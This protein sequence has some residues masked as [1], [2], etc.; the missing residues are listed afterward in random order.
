MATIVTGVGYTIEIDVSGLDDFS[1][2][3]IFC[4]TNVSESL[5]ETTDTWFKLCKSGKASNKITSLDPQWD[6]T[7]KAEKTD[8]ALS[9]LLSKKYSTDRAVAIRII[10]NLSNEKIEFIAEMTTISSTREVASVVEL[11]VTFKLTD[12]SID[13]VSSDVE[14]LAVISQNINDAD[15]D[16]AIDIA[17]EFVFDKI[18]DVKTVSDSNVI[19]SIDGGARIDAT[20][21]YDKFTKKLII[22]PDADLDNIE[23]YK[24]VITQDLKGIFNATLVDE[25]IVNFTTIA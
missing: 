18:L 19:L 20:L 13:I 2:M 24:L 14:V 11:S 25:I 12:G 16:I 23:N 21:I 17:I 22:T 15:I 7:V 4:V 3:Q 9:H 1:D 10:D 8:L 6:V 5:N